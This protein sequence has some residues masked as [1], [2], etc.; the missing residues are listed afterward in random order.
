VVQSETHLDAM[1]NVECRK[2]GLARGGSDRPLM[3]NKF[4]ILQ[5][6]SER[7]I[8]VVTGSYNYTQTASRSLENVVCIRDAPNV[9]EAYLR[10]FEELWKMARR[11]TGRRRRRR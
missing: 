1:A 2:I 7:V 3:H 8:A 4:M 9:F 6:R 5:D 11:V 10:E